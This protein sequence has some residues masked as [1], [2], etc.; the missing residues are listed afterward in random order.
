VEISTVIDATGNPVGVGILNVTPDSPAAKAGLQNGD[1]IIKVDDTPV[2]TAQA[3]QEALAQHKPGDT[4]H[5]TF[6][7]PPGE[8]QTITITLGELPAS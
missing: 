4:V 6:L 7:R 5:V 1:V 2:A 8:A 3:L